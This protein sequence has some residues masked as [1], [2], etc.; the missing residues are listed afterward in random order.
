MAELDLDNACDHCGP[1]V[2]AFVFVDMPS[3]LPLSFC[4]HCGTQ[5]IPA[6]E[7]LGAT[8]YDMRDMIEA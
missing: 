7:A 4:G 5:F 6:L 1:A 3:G 8:V 2:R